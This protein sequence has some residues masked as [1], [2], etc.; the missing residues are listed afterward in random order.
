MGK[1]S[2]SIIPDSVNDPTR[3]NA[4]SHITVKADDKGRCLIKFKGD[5]IQLA[6]MIYTMLTENDE[7]AAVVCEVTK[8]YLSTVKMNIGKWQELTENCREVDE[9]LAHRHG[10]TVIAKHETIEGIEQSHPT[11]DEQQYGKED[12]GK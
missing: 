9:R 5:T 8:D 7:L 3:F 6:D 4:K 11:E 1:L 10:Y 2:T 12:T